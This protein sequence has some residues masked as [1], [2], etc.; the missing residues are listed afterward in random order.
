VTDTTPF[1]SL[2]R[3]LYPLFIF[4]EEIKKFTSVSYV[5]PK[6]VAVRF[7]GVESVT[8]QKLKLIPHVGDL[9]GFGLKLMERTSTVIIGVYIHFVCH[10]NSDFNS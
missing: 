10:P 4:L 5:S 1:K 9:V 6:S 3:F 7:R 8:L 2:F